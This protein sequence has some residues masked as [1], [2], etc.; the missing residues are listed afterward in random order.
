MMARTVHLSDE[1]YALLK[2]LKRSDESFSDV[3]L[4]ETGSGRDPLKLLELAK[5]MD[6]NVD[7]DEI[8]RRRR[9]MEEERD[10]KIREQLE[11]GGG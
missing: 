1:A 8:R 10:R 11:S 3:V 9:S 6:P 4:R 2:A 7:V 5:H